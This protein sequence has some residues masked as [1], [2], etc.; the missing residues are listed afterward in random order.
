MPRLQLRLSTLAL[1]IVIIAL[2]A[3][4][5]VQW[6]RET[7]QNARMRV[8]ESENARNLRILDRYTVELTRQRQIN[9][10]PARVPRP[11]GEGKDASRNHPIEQGG[12]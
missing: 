6:R 8:L 1:L 7:V 12:R 4:V 3:A 5:L 9:Q 11:S 2:A 10:L